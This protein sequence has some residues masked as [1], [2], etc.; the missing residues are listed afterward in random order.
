[1]LA[2]YRVLFIGS[3]I[4]GLGFAFMHYSTSQRLA[5]LQR[6]PT[7]VTLE[8]AGGSGAENGG[9]AQGPAKP[10]GR[11]H[12]VAPLI[13]VVVE[14]IPAGFTERGTSFSLGDGLWLTARHVANKDCAEIVL[15]V[16][17]K[18]VRAQLGFLDRNADV[19]VLQAGATSTPSLP[20][21]ASTIVEGQ[22]A[23]AFGFPSG[24]LGAMEDEAM[25]GTR[26]RL[27]GRLTGIA[28]VVVWAEIRRF[29]HDITTMTGISGGPMLDAKGRVVGIVVATS[30]RRGRA[31]TIAP[32]ILRAV[33]ARLGPR[34]PEEQVPAHDAVAQPVSLDKSAHALSHN[35]RIAQT[36]CI[37]D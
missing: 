14:K 21:E 26:L 2:F 33:E 24:S 30:V 27:G 35:A 29:P 5:D 15:I 25:G 16:N 17:G 3:I 18:N 1:M 19:A 8:Q 37:P 4:A 32:Q 22:R 13:S 20:I 9:S 23:F 10:P 34:G 11:P 28:P 7:P 12:S 36:Y 6:R 31:I